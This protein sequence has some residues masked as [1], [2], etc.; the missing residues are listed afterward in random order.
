VGSKLFQLRKLKTTKHQRYQLNK[1]GKQL[2][3]IALESV[4]MKD[5]FGILYSITNALGQ[6]AAILLK[7]EDALMTLGYLPQEEMYI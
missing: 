1:Y 3:W 4:P 7:N 5:K 2:R 6:L